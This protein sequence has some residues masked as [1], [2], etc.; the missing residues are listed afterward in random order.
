MQRAELWLLPPHFLLYYLSFLSAPFCLL[1]SWP[2]T[3]AQP[4]L[5]ASPCST[6]EPQHSFSELCCVL[7]S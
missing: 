1:L 6:P 4:T 7:L 2:G 3:S 5:V